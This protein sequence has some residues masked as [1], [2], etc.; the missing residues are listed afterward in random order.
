MACG[1][2][3]AGVKSVSTCFVR[4]SIQIFDLT[5]LDNGGAV[6]STRFRPLS[7]GAVDPLQLLQN[8]SIR[9]RGDLPYGS[10][11]YILLSPSPDDASKE[12]K[13][14]S[15]RAHRNV[16]FGA[17]ASISDENT[18]DLLPKL[19]RPLVD[20][21]LQDASSQGEQPQAI[22]TLHGL[23]NW[24]RDCLSTAENSGAV[25]PSASK[26]ITD[27]LSSGD[28]TKLEAVRAIATG[29]PRPGHSVVGQGTFR[30]AGDAWEKLAREFVLL[31]MSEES[32]LYRIPVASPSAAAGSVE[33]TGRIAELVGIELLADTRPEYLK[34]A[35]GAMARFFFM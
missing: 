7:S 34:S 23:C 5:A 28:H 1:R 17:S 18:P 24:V 26:T 13:L 3:T 25:E 33:G 16:L 10:R 27:L 20:A 11:E 35:G 29:I 4:R 32:Q 21:A 9:Q 31:G 2:L 8:A 6:L 19:C 14:A 30:D 22:A 12:I 15:L